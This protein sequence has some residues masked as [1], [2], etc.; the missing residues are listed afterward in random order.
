[1]NK[2]RVTAVKAQKDELLERLLVLGCVE[3]TEPDELLSDPEV[4]E[5]VSREPVKTDVLKASQ[6]TVLRALDV[7]N[8]HAPV[9]SPMFVVRTD[10]AADEF[11]REDGLEETLSLAS[12]LDNLDNRVRHQSAEEAREAAL[13]ESLLPWAS[14]DL[15]L[16][17]E[18]TK[19]S[20]V[21]LGSVP[22]GTDFFALERAVSDAVTEVS[23]SRI[24][25]DDDLLYLCII[26]LREKLPA[27]SESLR[28]FG[29]SATA[30]REIELSAAEE[31]KQTE[32]RIAA[33]ISS[34]DALNAEILELAPRR[35]ELLRCGELLATKIARAE[36][37]ERFVSTASSVTFTGWIPEE[38]VA[39][40]KDALGSYDCAYELTEPTEDEYPSVPVELKSNKFTGPLSMVTEMYSLPA[41]GSLDPNPLMAPFFILF[42]GMM[43]ADVGYGLLMVI[44]GLFITHRKKPRGTMGQMFGLAVWCG[45]S[46]I[47]WGMLT[48][49]FFGDFIPQ[50]LKIFNPDST[51]EWFYKPLFTPL[52]DTVMILIGS[53]ILGFI[54]LI[55]GTI[56]GFVR[57]VKLGNL[58]DGIFEEGTW[59]VIFAG[60]I[61]AIGVPMLVSDTAAA[62][63][64]GTVGIVILVV[65]IAMLLIGGARGKKGF[66]IITGPF[67]AIYNGVTG[68][69]GD[70]LSYSRLMALML[71]G[72]VIAQVFNTIGAIPGNIVLFIIIS[73]IGN[74]LNF[75]LNLL[76]CFVHDLR[77][78]CLEFFGKFYEDGGVPFRPLKIFSKHNNVV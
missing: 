9:K 12:R 67:G 22:A 17:F 31:I 45:I 77:L 50:I 16:N 20:A 65:G 39:A 19:T 51:W 41:Y 34:R 74:A 2:L 37:E 5:L 15:P 42:Y 54:H 27:L 40:M 60:A 26:Y 59:W 35:N 76:G 69:F 3:I 78:Q 10:V 7:L 32:K 25:Q 66:G 61:V 71:A 11:L 53:L 68:W 56:I 14:L 4:A 47:G 70:I 33:L 6:Q 21:L 73:L 30:P 58:V 24:N 75:A 46:T 43:L 55:T 8:R 28:E 52:N 44:V 29:F 63:T 36:A 18:G 49:G 38:S 64:I 13:I 72:S 48:G 57:K 23:V 62:D 1:M